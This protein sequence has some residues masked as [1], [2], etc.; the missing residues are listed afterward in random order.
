VARGALPIAVRWSMWKPLRNK[1]QRVPE[2]TGVVRAV[3]S[4]DLDEEPQPGEPAEEA[5]GRNG[6]DGGRDDDMQA[7]LDPGVGRALPAAKVERGRSS[8]RA[9]SRSWDSIPSP[10]VPPGSEDPQSRGERWR[11]PRYDVRVSL[12]HQQ[13]NGVASN[14]VCAFGP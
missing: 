6:D 12:P 11:S 13:A 4:G 7:H 3:I 14:F 5:A 2:L 10:K 9:P 1:C 8:L